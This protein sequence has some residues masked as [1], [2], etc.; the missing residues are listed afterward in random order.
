MRV[1]ANILSWLE[2]VFCSILSHLF[3]LWGLMWLYKRAS[4]TLILRHSDIYAP[5]AQLEERQFPKLE[6]TGSIPV[7]CAT[8]IINTPLHDSRCVFF[9]FGL[10]HLSD[11]AHSLKK[12]KKG[13]KQNLGQISA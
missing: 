7:G 10:R 4:D 9:A 13:P 2:V 3:P 8:D 6:A 1:L 12:A 5:I 11:R